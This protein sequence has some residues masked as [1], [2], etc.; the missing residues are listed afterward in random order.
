MVRRLLG[1]RRYLV[2][3]AVAGRRPEQPSAADRIGTVC[4]HGSQ[5]PQLKN[6]RL[7]RFAGIRVHADGAFVRSHAVRL[8]GHAIYCT[9]SQRIDSSESEPSSSSTAWSD[10]EVSAS[11]LRDPPRHVVVTTL[12]LLQQVK[13]AGTDLLWAH[14]T[15][16][17]QRT[18]RG[19]AI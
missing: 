17:A 5:K 13:G 1:I 15:V 19:V 10:P 6:T 2:R 9:N 7:I 12:D 3:V 8:G 4:G 18:R 11:G 16:V 14:H